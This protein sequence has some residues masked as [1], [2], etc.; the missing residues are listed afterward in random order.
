MK[1]ILFGMPRIRVAKPAAGMIAS[2][3]HSYLDNSLAM[4]FVAL[5]SYSFLDVTIADPVCGLSILLLFIGSGLCSHETKDDY[6]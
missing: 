1:V 6:F 4:Y 5:K 3:I 2:K